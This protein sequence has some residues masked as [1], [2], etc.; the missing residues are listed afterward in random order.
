MVGPQQPPVP[1][2]VPVPA[3]YRWWKPLTW[4]PSGREDAATVVILVL[5]AIAAVMAF[6]RGPAL[7]VQQSGNPAALVPPAACTAHKGS[8]PLLKVTDPSGATATLNIF[9]GRGGGE[10]Q[11]QTSPLAIQ[12]GSLPPGTTL[13]TS[14]SDLV[15]ADGQALPASQVASWAKVDNDG[16]HVTV[17]VV[18]APRY[19][20]V[21][22][23]G[24]YS[25][26]VS[27]D[28][29]R[30]F[31]ADV[32]VNVHVEYYD[33][34]HP[35]A[36]ALLAAFG[37]FIWAWFIHRHTADDSQSFWAGLT[38]RV[39]V[40]LVATGPVVNAQV[41]TNPDWEGSLS[42]YITLASLTGA[43]AIAATPTLRVITT[44]H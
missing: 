13:C 42:Q 28:D 14:I 20:F 23:F 40:L 41:L 17:F 1:V 5:L 31:G 15:R 18:A 19:H 39:A 10:V 27:L 25:G 6:A 36:W 26:T 12:T 4:P 35:V 44:R 33:I 8:S 21:S 32:P 16:T 34:A 38:L 37:G 43:A 7:A 24:G 30:A 29:S 9:I 22:G 3:D 11:R 2:P